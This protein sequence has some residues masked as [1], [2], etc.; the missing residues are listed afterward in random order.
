M[1]NKENLLRRGKNKEYKIKPN[2]R[3]KDKSIYSVNTQIKTEIETQR[4]SNIEPKIS[5]KI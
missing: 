1:K 5:N 4:R 3:D 2:N